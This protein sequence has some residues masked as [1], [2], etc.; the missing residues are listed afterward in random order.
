MIKVMIADDNPAFCK[1]CFEFLTKDKDIKVVSY[2]NDGEEAIK[3]YLNI[4]PDVLL[5]DVNMPK[6]TGFEVINTLSTYPNEKEKCNIIVMTGE[7][8]MQVKLYN[9]SKVYSILPKPVGFEVVLEKVKELAHENEELDFSKLKDILLEFRINV[10]S[11]SYK[12]LISLITLAYNQPS[13]LRNIKDLYIQ[14]AKQYHVSPYTIK[15]SIRNISDILNRTAS[16]DK[17]CDI[18]NLKYRP[19]SIS[20]KFFITLIIEYLKNSRN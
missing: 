9:M 14:V 5:L 16:I 8:A 2:V 13:L 12:Y 1:S 15:W 17:I 19:D 11:N 3:K 10:Y 4:Q 6:A 20:P 7:T 18:F